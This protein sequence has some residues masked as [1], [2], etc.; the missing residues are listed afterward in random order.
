MMDYRTGLLLLTVCWAACQ[1]PSLCKVNFLTVC[2]KDLISC[3]Q[4]QQ[5]KRSSIRSPSTPTMFSVALLC[6]C[7]LLDPVSLTEAE[8]LTE[9]SH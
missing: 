5:K 3:C 7:W 1:C 6:C 8:T 9:R 4:L 2:Y